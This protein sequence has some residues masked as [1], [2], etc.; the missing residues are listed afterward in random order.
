MAQECYSGVHMRLYVPIGIAAVVLVC[1]APPLGLFAVLWRSRQRLDEPRV[2]QQYGF[3]YMRYKSRF[4][5]WESVLMLEELALVAVEVFGRGLPA[6]SHHILLMLA[7]FILVSMVNMACAPTRSRL[8]GLLEFLSMGVLGLTVTLSLYFVVGTEL[9][10]SGV[11]G[12]LGVLIVFI[13]VAL[14]FTLL[15]AVLMKSWPS[16]R[17]KSFKL[18]QGASKRLNGPC[19]GGAN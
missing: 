12:F 19:F 3:L 13:N 5:W 14:L 18:W 9:I 2:Q 7:A 8:V 10:S 17:T 6:V 15:L 1:L 11:Q 16:V 4:F